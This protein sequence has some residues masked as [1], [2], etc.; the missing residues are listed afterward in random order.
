MSLEQCRL[1]VKRKIKQAKKILSR[2][3][4]KNKSMKIASVANHP[5]CLCYR[6]TR[7]IHLQQIKETLKNKQNIWQTC[8]IATLTYFRD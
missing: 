3:E 4:K 6:P 2:V 1:T 5:V 7:N 8:V